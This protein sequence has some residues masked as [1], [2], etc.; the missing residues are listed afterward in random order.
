MAAVQSPSL[1]PIGDAMAS[2]QDIMDTR[3]PSPVNANG[4]AAP[5]T[6]EYKPDLGAELSML[7]TKLVN[8]INY[9]TNLDDSLQQTRHEL[10]QARQELAQIRAQKKLT[11]DQIADGVLVKKSIM[12]NTMNKLRAD[13]GTEK[14][15]RES[16][17][18][19]KKQ[20][21]SEL[22]NLTTAL[23][24]EAN[25]MVAAARKDT[26]AAEKR[27]GQIRAQLEDTELLLASQTEQLRDLKDNMER[28]EQQSEHG[29]RDASVPATPIDSRTSAWDALQ[30]PPGGHAHDII[31]NHPLHFTQLLAPVMR[32]DTACYADFHELLLLAQRAAPLHS[33]QASGSQQNLGSASSSTPNLNTTAMNT[34]TPVP[35]LPGSF[36]SGSANNSPSSST[37]AGSQTALPSLKDSKFY[38]RSLTEDIEPTLRLDTAPGLSFLSRRSVLSSLLSGSLAV[39]PFNAHTKVYG[40]GAVFAC[41]LCGE[42]RKVDPFIRRFRFRTSESDDAQRYP[43]CDWCLGR[44]RA[45]GDFVG[46]LRLVREGFVRVEKEEDEASAWEESV[47]LR[48]RMFWARIGGGVVPAQFAHRGQITDGLESVCGIKS[49]RHSLDS[50][51]ESSARGS[52]EVHGAESSKERGAADEM[53]V[54]DESAVS[55]A[56]SQQ[57]PATPALPF[58]AAVAL[59][60][61]ILVEEEQPT[62]PFEDAPT[63]LSSQDQN[64]AAD[65]QLQQE[66]AANPGP[67][68]STAPPIP[69]VQEPEQPANNQQTTSSSTPETPETS[70]SA[71]GIA[72]PRPQTAERRPSAVLARVKAMEAAGNK[73]PEKRLPG[74]FE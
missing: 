71:S 36:F 58:D 49:P 7:S 29:G 53:Q 56:P 17:E 24:E 70:E 61:P 74:A 25:T 60:T 52:K 35:T 33:R 62:T 44:V 46:F 10:E 9:Q 2:A 59:P 28:L 63:D 12:D 14:A 45:T 34:S 4:N 20:T 11:D 15:A 38:K 18:K 40:L 31:P 37:F 73:S 39:E 65:E 27:N 48:E 69:L 19:A 22:E 32:T 51:P 3:T 54:V 72:P 43:L 8:A 50:I 41:S 23:F 6:T 64:A 1:A 66:I 42:S 30:L 16:A 21:E 55:S 26:E 13:L 5:A 47:R 67:E 68:P 57:E